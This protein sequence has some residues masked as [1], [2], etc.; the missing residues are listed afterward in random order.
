MNSISFLF[1]QAVKLSI[2]ATIIAAIIF[3]IKKVLGNKL[4]PNW[5][6][7]IL[8][9]I[10]IRLIVPYS[11]N[12]SV[13]VFKFIDSSNQIQVSVN[14]SNTKALNTS[15][16]N[17]QGSS[18][19]KNIKNQED[20]K[21]KPSIIYFIEQIGSIVWVGIMTILILYIITTYVIFK[22][23]IRNE[24]KLE[25]KETILILKR[26]RK[27]MN[28]KLDIPVLQSKVVSTPCI[29]GIVKPVILFPKEMANKLSAEDKKYIF[30][31][32][33]VHFKR[34]DNLLSMIFIILTIIYW[35]NPIIY[36]AF[37][38]V[39]VECEISCDATALS[40]VRAKERK[41]YGR[42]IVNLIQYVSLKDIK[43][44][45]SGSAN[46]SDMKKR[47]I[48]IS[49]FKRN[50]SIKVISGVL[51]A[52]FVGAIAFTYTYAKADNKKAASKK[53]VNHESQAKT[54]KVKGENITASTKASNTTVTNSVKNSLSNAETKPESS[55]NVTSDTKVNNV[56]STNNANSTSVQAASSKTVTNSNDKD[57]NQTSNTE[58]FYGQWKIDKVVGSSRV[59]AYSESD[60]N[61]IIGKNLSFSKDES[62]CFGDDISSLN[63]TVKNPSYNKTTVSNDTFQTGYRTNYS[64]SN[65]NVTQ[66]QI[67]DKTGFPACIF[68]IKDNNT[69][70]LSGGGD[71]FQLSRVN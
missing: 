18:N 13:S 49:K 55:R 56:T 41:D 37:K 29:F 59:S 31:H 3:I 20:N 14:N 39:K 11:F 66:V 32:E 10:A 24:I 2:M 60:I 33:L 63:E 51:V 35:F 26:C 21:K 44:W 5:H 52:M 50:T 4:S 9:L 30:M 25:D 67:N 48:M 58:T 46:K 36:L 6:Y 43:P 68:Y 19:D 1:L 69:L 16:V 34:K 47:I 53:Q 57:A 65:G 17:I 8:F 28:I 15:N 61:N 64:I 38:K 70:I 42:A 54:N 40:Y 7:Y 27:L 12:T 23:K 22:I 62:S 71:F 45:I